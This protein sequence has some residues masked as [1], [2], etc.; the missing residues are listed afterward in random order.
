MIRRR[1]VVISAVEI[2]TRRSSVGSPTASIYARRAATVETTTASTVKSSASATAVEAATTTA[3]AVSPAAMLREGRA[4]HAHERDRQQR[5]EQKLEKGGPCHLFTLHPTTA[6]NGHVARSMQRD[7]PTRL[8]SSELQ[9]VA[10]RVSRSQ[11]TFEPVRGTIPTPSNTG[12]SIKFRCTAGQGRRAFPW[13]TPRVLPRL[14][15]TYYC[16][17]ERLISS[18]A[19]TDSVRAWCL[20]QRAFAAAKCLLASRVGRLLR[21]GNS[22]LASGRGG[23]GRCRYRCLRRC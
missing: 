6:R 11:S 15:S 18:G 3:A 16:F 23:D 5:C 19:V 13:G 14:F 7:R 21:R 2:S 1:R 9:L 12:D 20:R 8:D 4:G 22:D 17:F 10:A